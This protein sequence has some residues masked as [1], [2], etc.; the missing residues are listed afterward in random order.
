M[1]FSDTEVRGEGY[2]REG[3]NKKNDFLN[4]LLKNE[5]Y[6]VY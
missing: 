2:N 5:E 6:L 1:H 3:R 4:I